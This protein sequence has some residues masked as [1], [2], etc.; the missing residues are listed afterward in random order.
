MDDVR[1]PF[2]SRSTFLPPFAPRP[3]LRFFAPMEALTPARLSLARRGIPDSRH[4]NVFC[5][6]VPNHPVSSHVRFL[7]ARLFSRSGAVTVGPF[8]F[9]A[10]RFSRLRHSIAGSSRHKAESTSSRTD[11][12]T[13]LPLLSTPPSGDAVTVGFQPVERL[14]ESVFTSSSGALSGARPQAPSPASFCRADS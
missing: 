1:V 10:H 5:R 4:L 9:R 2:C 3:L 13:R 14:V 6:S 8:P 12:Q 7:F 11:R